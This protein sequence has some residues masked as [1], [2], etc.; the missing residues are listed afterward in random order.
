[1]ST[2]LR[3]LLATQ[4]TL[5]LQEVSAEGCTPR[6]REAEAITPG[7]QQEGWGTDSWVLGGQVRGLDCCSR[8]RLAGV[9]NLVSEG[10]FWTLAPG[11]IGGG[12]EPGLLGMKVL[13]LLNYPSLPLPPD[14][15]FLS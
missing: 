4:V 15:I 1:M 6:L 9:Q 13:G 10:K 8:K 14:G 2:V 7:T 5:R 12:V 3:A 11:S